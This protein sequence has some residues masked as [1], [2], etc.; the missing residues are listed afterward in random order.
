MRGVVDWLKQWAVGRV[1]TRV[2]H[3]CELCP[4][5]NE[6]PRSV[7]SDLSDRWQCVSNRLFVENDYLCSDTS[8]AP[9]VVRHTPRSVARRR[10]AFFVDDD[11]YE[12]EAEAR[13]NPLL[14]C[15]APGIGKASLVSDVISAAKSPRQCRFTR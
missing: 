13:P 12:D 10:Q 1:L 2:R 15:G 6:R 9:C 7:M 8:Q 4:S 14:L 5:T 3:V 11:E